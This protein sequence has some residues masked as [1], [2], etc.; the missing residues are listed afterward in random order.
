MP[1]T[2]EPIYCSQQ[3]NIPPEL[4]DI[5]KQFTKAAIRT[6]PN[7]VLEWS[8]AYFE[9][10][11]KGEPLPVK[12]RL[13][14]PVGSALERPV[15][16]GF[17][18]VLHKQL[19]SKPIIEQSSLQEKWKHLSL[20]DDRLYEIL[21]LGSFAEEITWVHFLSLAAVTISENLTEAMKTVCEILTTDLEGGPS[22]IDFKVFKELY[23][24]LAMIDGEIPTEHVNNVLEHLQYDVEKQNGLISSQHF[25]HESC[26]PLAPLM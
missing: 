16:K 24:Y 5:L 19:G 12:D 21:R 18:E 11:S 4:P 13:E 15:S 9:A 22:R 3:I 17:L 14:V 20:P 2:D 26:P 8:A 23:T 1:A 7:D 25:M 6:Q 10:L